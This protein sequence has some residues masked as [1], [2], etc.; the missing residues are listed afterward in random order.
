MVSKKI[1]I[2]LLF[3][4]LISLVFIA[5]KFSNKDYSLITPKGF[6]NNSQ[7]FEFE[8]LTIPYL[9]EKEYKSTLGNLEEYSKNS[10]YTSY[11]A[12][13][14]SE[15]LKING[16]LTI[17]EGKSPKGGWPAIVFIHGYIPPTLY[18]TTSRYADYV[19]YLAR[20]GFV[21]FKIDLRGHGKSEGQPGG[22][23]YS[24]DYIIDTLNAYAALQSSN[25]V[26]SSRIGLWGHSM[27]GNVVLRSL[28]AKP[29]IPAVVIWAGAVYSYMDLAKHRLNDQSY[30]PSALITQR[31][32]Q[33]QKLFNTYGQFDENSSFWKQVAATN[34]LSDIKGAIQLNHATDDTVVDIGY[35][36]DLNELLDKTSI[37][38]EFYEY[39]SGRHN[40]TGASFTQAMQ[41]TVEFFNK[42]LK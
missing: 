18:E 3:I 26:D 19:D 39:A 24:S 4:S 14:N 29:E 21:V 28:A 17:P 25:F 31:Q 8:E 23:Y 7:A 20:N 27:A 34:Y 15:G 22:A 10:N 13:Y 38:H 12:S 2:L 11:L 30:R 41:N 36:R 35:S 9:R 37:P 1:L 40:F 32:G 5:V 42:Y 6:I 16:L 33:R